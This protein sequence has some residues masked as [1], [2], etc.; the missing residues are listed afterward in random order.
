M[1]S[2]G[3][4]NIRKRNRK[5]KNII[6]RKMKKKIMTNLNDQRMKTSKCQETK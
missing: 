3:K 2:E 6:E 1:G 4:W 5:M